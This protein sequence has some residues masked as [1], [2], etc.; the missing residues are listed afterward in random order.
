[1]TRATPSS[2]DLPTLETVYVMVREHIRGCKVR[3][4]IFGAM[5]F[6][7]APAVGVVARQIWINSNRL[8]AIEANVHDVKE[9]TAEVRLLIGQLRLERFP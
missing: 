8:T 5:I 3:S 4:A 6:L 1:M 9:L 7:M 2:R